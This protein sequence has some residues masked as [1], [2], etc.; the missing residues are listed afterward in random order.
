MSANSE[1]AFLHRLLDV[2]EGEIV[3]LTRVG[4]ARGDKVFG[5][6]IL[7]KA[8]LSLIVAGTNEETAN[9]LWHGEMSAIRHFHDLASSERP[10]PADCLFLAT[11]EPCPL[12]LSAITWA[13]FDNFH[14]L[15]GYQSTA[16]DFA[17]PHDLKILEEVFA[18]AKGAYR[19][20]NAYWTAHA[21]ADGVAAL[22]GAERTALE[23]R[24]EAIEATYAALSATY[25]AGK[26]ENDIPLS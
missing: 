14:Y 12:C 3:P 2:I 1:P 18:V 5:A 15:F 26:R 8:G 24:I 21:I 25:Q 13:G 16:E 17:I 4:V 19:R 7:L 11:H 22:T 10:A 20:K 9:P 23:V 6:A